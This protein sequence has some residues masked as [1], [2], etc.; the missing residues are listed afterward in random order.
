MDSRNCHKA[1]HKKKEKFEKRAKACFSRKL[2]SPA[3]ISKRKNP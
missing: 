3:K 1:S 2:F